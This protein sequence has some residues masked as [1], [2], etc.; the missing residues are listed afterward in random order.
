MGEIDGSL[1][2]Y[3]EHGFAVFRDVLDAGLMAE[4]NSHVDQLLLANPTLRADE[5]DHSLA[6]G[7]AFWY[8]LVSDPRLL[9]VAEQFI[10]PDIALFATH[11]ICKEPSVGREV[12]WH[13]DGAFWPLEPMEV[14][15]LWL[16]VG[17]STIDNGC[18]E[19]VP[20]SHRSELQELVPS[21]PDE[22]LSRKTP[23]AAEPVDAIALELEPGDVSVHHPAILHGSKPNQ[24]TSWRRGLTIRYIPTTT[25]ILDRSAACPYLLRGEAK[26][27]NAYLSAPVEADS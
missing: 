1:A 23:M 18:L 27:D 14:V 15:S 6:R 3:E 9:N 17:P 24:S 5:L 19:V 4:A 10:G 26:V 2:H 11:Y 25:R 8:R 13:Q 21:G 22:A 20:G 12:P 7:D 16:A